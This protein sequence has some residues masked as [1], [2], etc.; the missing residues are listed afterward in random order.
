VRARQPFFGEISSRFEFSKARSG[1]FEFLLLKFQID[2]L[3]K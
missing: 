2:D 1:L 3:M